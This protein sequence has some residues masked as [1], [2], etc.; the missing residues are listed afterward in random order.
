MDL[1]PTC[2]PQQRLDLRLVD[3]CLAPG[4]SLRLCPSSL[5]AFW[6]PV[7]TLAAGWIFASLR[8]WYVPLF[9]H[10]TSLSFPSFSPLQPDH[11]R[12][13]LL[14]LY[15][16]TR[17]RSP[18]SAHCMLFLFRPMPFSSPVNPIAPHPIQLR[19]TLQVLASVFRCFSIF[20]T[21]V[22]GLALCG[23]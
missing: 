15:V 8:P 4:H 5:P 9:S 6:H 3:L 17:S 10:R 18:Q 21:L 2:V 12:H 1:I 13:R 20:C 22:L 19:Y 23:S 16:P 7:Y 14:P 11:P